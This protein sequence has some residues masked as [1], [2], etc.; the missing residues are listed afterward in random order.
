M[1]TI[2]QWPHGRKQL[3]EQEDVTDAQ[4]LKLISGIALAAKTSG[5][6]DA[7]ADEVVKMLRQIITH[8]SDLMRELRRMGTQSGRAKSTLQKVR[9]DL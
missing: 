7:G 9:K 4:T 5:A 2:D 6:L 8:P 3:R 1:K